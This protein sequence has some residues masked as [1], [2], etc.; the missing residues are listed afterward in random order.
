M[1]TM[2]LDVPP[3]YSYLI[4]LYIPIKPPESEGNLLLNQTCLSLEQTFTF[5]FRFSL[6]VT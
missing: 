5:L 4:Q 3:L 1:E 6:K 2:Q